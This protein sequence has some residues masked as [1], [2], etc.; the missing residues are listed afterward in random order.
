MKPSGSLVIKEAFIST[1]VVVDAAPLSNYNVYI[2]KNTFTHTRTHIRTHAHTHTS[3]SSLN[4][5]ARCLIGQLTHKVT[6]NKVMSSVIRFTE[7]RA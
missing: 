4:H 5:N 1:G 2:K 3:D 7:A 6:L